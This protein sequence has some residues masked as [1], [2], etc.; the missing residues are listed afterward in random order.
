MKCK[1]MSLTFFIVFTLESSFSVTPIGLNNG[2]GYSF[3]SDY[4]G[5]A[6]IYRSFA[7]DVHNNIVSVAQVDQRATI[8]RHNN[9]GMLDVT[10]NQTGYVRDLSDQDAAVYNDIGIAGNSDIIVVGNTNINYDVIA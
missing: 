1:I 6:Q 3:F 5:N 7:F 10:F 8:V 4:L 2:K 9:K